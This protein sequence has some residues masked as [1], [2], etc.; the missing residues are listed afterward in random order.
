MAIDKSA[1]LDDYKSG[2]TARSEKWLREY[3]RAPDK[4]RKAASDDAEKLYA[5]K[6]TAAIARK[7]RQ[8][9]L[10]KVSESDF[11]K[12]AEDAG[13]GAYSSGVTAKADKALKKVGPYLDE[14][15]RLMPTMPKRGA[16]PMTNLTSRAG[17]IV[18]GLADLKKKL[19]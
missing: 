11:N 4:Q 1:W 18:K 19:G 12:G 14:I 7:A 10:S 17:H 3:L 9:S 6:V 16:D 13:S 8:K 2:A 5:E 15:D